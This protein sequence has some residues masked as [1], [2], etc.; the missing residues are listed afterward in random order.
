MTED[1]TVQ[2]QGSNRMACFSIVNVTVKVI[3]LWGE[4]TPNHHSSVIAMH[5]LNLPTLLSSKARNTVQYDSTMLK[6]P[7]RVY[8]RLK[9]QS[10]SFLPLYLNLILVS[11]A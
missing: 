10:T 3:C 11:Y 5:F 2:K 1:N 7:F 8:L 9:C 4:K 6:S